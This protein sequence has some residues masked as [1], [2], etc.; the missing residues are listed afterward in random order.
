M[1]FSVDNYIYD[2]KKNPGESDAYHNTKGN[3]IA[4]LKPID[5]EDL[6]YYEKLGSIY[7]NIIHLGCQY[8]QEVISELNDVGRNIEYYKPLKA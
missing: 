3:F 2:I 1:I 5:E 7:A 6:S 8:N 4:N